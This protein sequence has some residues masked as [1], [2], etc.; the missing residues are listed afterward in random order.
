MCGMFSS[1]PG[2]IITIIIIIDIYWYLLVLVLCF[3]VVFVLQ[4][5]KLS[6]LFSIGEDFEDEVIISKYN[7]T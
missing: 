1:L 4:T 5:C 3:I 2:H 6:G 7:N